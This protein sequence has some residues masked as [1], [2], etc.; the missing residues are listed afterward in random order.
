MN[1]S[2]EP[3]SRSRSLAPALFLCA[4][5]IFPIVTAIIYVAPVVSPD[6]RYVLTY[7]VAASLLI[8]TIFAWLA[9]WLQ[10]PV[11][12]EVVAAQV[13]TKTAPKV[14]PP[15]NALDPETRAERR[16]RMAAL[17]EQVRAETQQSFD[18]QEG[19]P[20]VPV[21]ARRLAAIASDSTRCAERATLLLAAADGSLM[22]LAAHTA[23][24]SRSALN[25]EGQ[26]E[27]ARAIAQDAARTATQSTASMRGL[28]DKA[29][30][31]GEL[32]DIIQAIAA[33][34]SLLSLNAALEAARAGEAGRGFALV[35]Q[36]VKSLAGQT[37]RATDRVA[38]HV[39]AIQIAT[40]TAMGAIA[41][42]AKTAS[43]VEATTQGLAASLLDQ[44]ELTR[45]LM[46]RTADAQ[47]ETRESLD[48]LSC[49]VKSAEGRDDLGRPA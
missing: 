4:A 14:A 35:A 20:D 6:P 10:R 28:S 9:V 42:I 7:G 19:D 30:E 46:S 47:R 8:V 17:I 27:G 33:Q 5:L 37:A 40:G 44:A 3:T 43:R 18:V 26:I 2:P 38:E 12:R 45:D 13:E 34:T 29:H 24:V 15:L 22:R 11:L 1:L 31:I 39:S 21:L 49:T 16:A 48:E 41:A 25:I 32:I 36:E 23:L